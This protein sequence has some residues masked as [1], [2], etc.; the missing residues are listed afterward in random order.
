M[1]NK[2]QGNKNNSNEKEHPINNQIKA[3]YVILFDEKGQKV[4]DKV[5]LAEAIYRANNQDLDL[6]EVGRDPKSNEVA[7]C[8]IINYSS[9]LYHEQKKKHKQEIKNKAHDTKEM[10]FRP[11]TGEHDLM[12]KLNKCKE[13]LTDGH[14]VKIV[15]TM[16]GREFSNKDGQNDFVN[17]VKTFFGDLIVMDSEPKPERNGLFFVV[18]PNPNHKQKH[19]MN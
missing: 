7:V 10:R 19:K 4:A 14:K 8:K 11:V 1:L 16:K 18:R 12:V 6:V 5:V 13:F 2:Y 15:L 3:K 17:K 9:W